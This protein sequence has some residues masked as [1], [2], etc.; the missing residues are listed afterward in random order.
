MGYRLEVAEVEP[1][2]TICGGKLYGYLAG[3]TEDDGLCELKSYQWLKEQGIVNGDEYWTYGCSIDRVLDA[4]SFREFYDL[5]REDYKN[6]K[7]VELDLEGED[8]DSY[9][10]DK[11]K[12]I[13]WG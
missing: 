8:L 11:D 10:N 4:E 12:L 5:Y 9:N 3:C 1:K 2:Y 13:T 7:G 6:V